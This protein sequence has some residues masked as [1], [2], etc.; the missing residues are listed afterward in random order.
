MCRFCLPIINVWQMSSINLNF[1]F[2]SEDLCANNPCGTVNIIVFN[3]FVIMCFISRCIEMKQLYQ[4]I[5]LVCQRIIACCMLWL[6]L[7]FVSLYTKI[8]WKYCYKMSIVLYIFERIH[9]GYADLKF[10]RRH[11]KTNKQMIILST[12]NKHFQTRLPD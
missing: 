9:S 7:L 1:F 4:L 2:F 12:Q 10:C 8:I 11:A 3:R 5:S 6:V